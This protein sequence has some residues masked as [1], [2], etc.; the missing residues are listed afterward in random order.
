M[1]DENKVSGKYAEILEPE[2]AEEE[3]LD[4]W[5]V[6]KF[7]KGDM[8]DA[9]LEES[10][11]ATLFPKYREKYLREVW[12]HVTKSLDKF[13]VACVLDL[14]EGSMTVKTTRKTWDPYVIMKARDLIK[15]LARSVPFEQ[16]VK[17]LDDDK[18]CDVIKIL[19]MVRN[20]EKFVKRRSRLIGPNGNTLKAIELLTECY[21]MVQGSTVSVIGTHRGL[22]EV[23]R[24]VEDCM[25]N[26]HPIYNIKELMIK[27]E[28]RKDPKLKH[29]SWDRFLPNFKKRNVKS[30]Q[31]KK[32][33]KKK[34]ERSLF[35]PAAQPSKI[36]LQLESGEYFLKP[37]ERASNQQAAKRAAQLE[38]AVKKETNREKSFVPPKETNSKISN[39][40]TD[41]TNDISESEKIDQLKRKFKSQSDNK[42]SKHKINHKNNT[43]SN[44]SYFEPNTF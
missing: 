28:L 10:S 22:K 21:V 9:L 24:I 8:K 29:E 36:D 16:A 30:K 35:P 43:D 4:H 18:A 20:R 41:Q 42:S 19:S 5:E 32:I 1:A 40:S 31:P 11:F 6:P 13:G 2:V 27:N 34:K 17:I 37:E 25:S 7:E 26:V 3:S 44:A 39:N 14:V 23:R 15:L 12:P 33:G 38:H